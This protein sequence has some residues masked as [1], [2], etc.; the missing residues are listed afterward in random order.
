[1]SESSLRGCAVAVVMSVLGVSPS[2]HGEADAAD[3]R[4]LRYSVEI[5]RSADISLLDQ[6]ILATFPL[7]SYAWSECAPGVKPVITSGHEPG[8]VHKKDS[9]HYV[10][11]AIDLR[12]KNL[13]RSQFDCVTVELSTL[14][15][16]AFY[17]FPEWYGERVP[18]TH[19]HLQ[20]RRGI[21]VSS[22]LAAKS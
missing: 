13:S 21:E 11:A 19:I 16:D 22:A 17:V 5:K 18:K 2:G 7:L 4:G 15:G 8:S 14:L 20:L 1:M 6:R 3:G 12:A 9:Q 10:G